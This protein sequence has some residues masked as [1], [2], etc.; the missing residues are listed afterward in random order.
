VIVADRVQ[1]G[2]VAGQR[3]ALVVDEEQLQLGPDGRLSGP[4][5]WPLE[6]LAQGRQAV[7]EPWRKRR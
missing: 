1:D 2:L 3:A 4:E 5:A 6:R 7:L